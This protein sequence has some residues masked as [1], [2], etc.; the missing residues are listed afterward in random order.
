MEAAAH[1]MTPRSHARVATWAGRVMSGVAILFLA[2]DSLVK[3]LRLPPAM[4][5]TAQLGYPLDVVFPLGVVL[6]VCV[7]TYVAPRT[8]V[9]GAILLTGYLGGAIAT[10][11]RV[12][13]PLFTHTLFPIY[14]AALIWGGVLLRDPRVRAVL[15]LS[16][17][18]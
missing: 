12:G 8:S 14:V 17:R 18:R 6:L 7:L 16:V 5:G 15:S 11:V 1:P 10:H 4:E 2:F 9:W 13:N 3:L